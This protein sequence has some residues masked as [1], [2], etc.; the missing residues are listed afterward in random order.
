MINLFEDCTF[1]PVILNKL[2]PEK[3]AELRDALGFDGSESVIDLNGSDI[4]LY[5][6]DS[7][8]IDYDR[9]YFDGQLLETILED[10]VGTHPHY[11]VFAANVRWNGHSGY[12]ICDDIMQTIERNY[13]F[14]LYKVRGFTDRALVC[15]ESSHDV[16]TG[17]NTVI[18]GLST[19][20]AEKFEDAEFEEIE[21]FVSQF[22]E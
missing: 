22:L 7:N 19:E 12:K 13:D 15:L 14:T 4:E 21:K 3:E 9:S 17:A 18:V 20:E 6:I 16:P 10:E 5:D 2:D 8:A 11:L 1:Y